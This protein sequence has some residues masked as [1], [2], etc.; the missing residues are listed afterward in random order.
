MY[1]GELR[2]SAWRIRT[3]DDRPMESQSFLRGRRRL[4]LRQVC[5]PIKKVCF[6]ESAVSSNKFIEFVHFEGL[7]FMFID[8]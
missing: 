3:A 4:H 2:G 8:D 7:D 1:G 5:S 6:S